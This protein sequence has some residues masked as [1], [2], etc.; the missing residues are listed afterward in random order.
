MSYR[1]TLTKRASKDLRKLP[2]S[3]VR[4]VSDAVD[5]LALD[6]APKGVKYLKGPLVPFRRVTVGSYRILYS[7]DDDARAVQIERV[8]HRQQA[9]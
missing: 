3:V 1:I 7:V 9:Y 6:Q 5:A 2:Q 8:R 4:R